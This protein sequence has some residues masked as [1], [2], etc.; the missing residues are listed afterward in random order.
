MLALIIIACSFAQKISNAGHQYKTKLPETRKTAQEQPDVHAAKSCDDIGVEITI[1]TDA[2][3]FITILRLLEMT[4]AN[5]SI[6]PDRM[7]R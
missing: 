1:V 4:D 7:L 2:S 3:T 5:A 6:V